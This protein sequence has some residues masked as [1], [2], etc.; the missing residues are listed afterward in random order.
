MKRL[1]LLA[2]LLLLAACG[3]AS[4]SAAPTATVTVTVTASP[5]EAA[6]SDAADTQTDGLYLRPE[7]FTL[8]VKITDKQC[9]G[10]AGC[11]IS[12]KVTPV[13]HGDVSLIDG[14]A[15]DITY[16]V[17]GDESGKQ[18]GTISVGDDGSFSQEE[19]TMTT[20]SSSVKV[21]ARATDVELY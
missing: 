7:D 2:P 16:S 12:Y 19:E 4:P 13:Y 14:M 18:I 8:K 5:E 21:T 6:T 17:S 10:S 11:S 1:A 9:F 3:G 20:K 15:Y